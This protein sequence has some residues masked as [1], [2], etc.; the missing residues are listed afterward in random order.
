M[1]DLVPS[2]PA[3]RVK[4]ADQTA[5]VWYSGQNLKGTLLAAAPEDDFFFPV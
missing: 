3:S 4:K 1:V 5:G 2:L